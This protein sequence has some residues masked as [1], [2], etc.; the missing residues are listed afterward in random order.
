MPEIY[1]KE[2]DKNLNTTDKA[3]SFTD[4]MYSEI[5]PY[6]KGNI[7]EIGSGIGTYS[8]KVIND[9]K[10]N[11]KVFTDIDLEYVSELKHIFKMDS[12]VTVSQL[13]LTSPDF[14]I[15]EKESFN[16]AFA[17]NVLEHIKEDELALNNIYDLLKPKGYFIMLVPA[18]KFLYN[19]IDKDL[20]HFRRYSKKELIY[21]IANTKFK[22]EKIYYFNFLSILGWY[23]NGNIFKK[24]VVN[25]KAVNLLN[26]IVPILKFF[27]K[28][29]LLNKMGISLIVVLKKE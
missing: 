15:F 22:L 20:G 5:K 21:K 24:S 9:F 19:C 7:L 23:V 4:W 17:L 12:T 11:K 1:S 25:E 13:D 27:E 18:H 10:K 3:N 26:K 28:Y 8:K 29:I 6:L 2:G 16:S 14:S